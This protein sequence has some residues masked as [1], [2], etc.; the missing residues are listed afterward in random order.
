MTRKNLLRTLLA[1]YAAGGFSQGR[2]ADAPAESPDNP[3]LACNLKALTTDQRRRHGQL[4]RQWVSAILSR[5]ALSDGYTFLIDS[6]A[7]SM[8]ELAEWIGY[9]RACCPFFRFRLDLEESGRLYLSLSG[10]P[11]VKRF[12]EA[13]F[14]SL[15]PG[16]PG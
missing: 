10:G 2:A 5:R 4:S 8:T 6:S 3:R 13:E 11:G 9:E 15:G 7:V 12:I 16:Q 1:A 14:A